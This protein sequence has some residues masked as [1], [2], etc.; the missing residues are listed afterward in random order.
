MEPT[1]IEKDTIVDFGT[2]LE[3]SGI[4]V[5]GPAREGEGAQHGPLQSFLAWYGVGP[6]TQYR[7]LASLR[8]DDLGE[9]G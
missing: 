8:I 4:P 7:V 9:A 3:W 1:A 2:L 5:Q 6:N